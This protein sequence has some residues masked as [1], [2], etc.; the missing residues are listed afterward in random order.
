[1]VVVGNSVSFAR[2]ARDDPCRK[3]RYSGSSNANRP[4]SASEKQ[5]FP[6]ASVPPPYHRAILVL[7]I[8]SPISCA[9]IRLSFVRNP[10]FFNAFPRVSPPQGLS[11][12]MQPPDGEVHMDTSMSD[13]PEHVPLDDMV[14]LNHSFC[15]D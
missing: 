10:T 9:L 6:T 14:R 4:F 1:M 5:I 3:I 15:I 11:A 8:I 12:I 7:L 2:K 13:V